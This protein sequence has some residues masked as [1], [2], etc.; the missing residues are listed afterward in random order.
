MFLFYKEYYEYDI[1]WKEDL[2]SSR[3]FSRREIGSVLTT[4]T[5]LT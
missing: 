3:V 1:V 2:V 5:R 4:E